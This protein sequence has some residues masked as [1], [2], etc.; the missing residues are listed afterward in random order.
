MPMDQ[1]G[2]SEWS[3]IIDS[4]TNRLKPSNITYQTYTRCMKNCE[5]QSTSVPWT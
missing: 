4:L 5:T 2:D 1:A 3:Q